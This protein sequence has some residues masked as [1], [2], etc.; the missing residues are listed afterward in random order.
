[1][2]GN[3]LIYPLRV[4]SNLIECNLKI[5]SKV[6]EVTGACALYV[7]INS[8]AIAQVVNLAVKFFHISADE[9]LVL[10]N[11]ESC[12]PSHLV[13]RK[14]KLVIAT[15]QL[16][17]ASEHPEESKHFFD[18]LFCGVFYNFVLHFCFT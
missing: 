1:M 3:L 8:T 9:I 18:L 16:L 14:Y 12:T 13:N 10:D 2:T 7:T 15:Y 11:A 5:I 17:T 4:I 6:M